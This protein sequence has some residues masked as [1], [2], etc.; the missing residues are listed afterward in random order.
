M[1]KI[2]ELTE[3]VKKVLLISEE[4]KTIT[5]KEGVDAAPVIVYNDFC[6]ELVNVAKLHPDKVLHEI[7]E[8]KE[9]LTAIEV[10]K[11]VYPQ[12]KLL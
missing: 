6:Q 10:L 2:E 5:Y 7:P 3:A 8:G 4:I 11:R 9:M 12:L 1:N